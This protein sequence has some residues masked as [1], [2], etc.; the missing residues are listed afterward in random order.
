MARKNRLNH[1]KK[2]SNATT[3]LVMAISAPIKFLILG[4]LFSSVAEAQEQTGAQQ[5]TEVNSSSTVQTPEVSS[6]NP[7][8]LDSDQDLGVTTADGSA[9]TPD[10]LQRDRRFSFSEDELAESL[11]RYGPFSFHPGAGYSVSYNDNIFAGRSGTALNT[12]SK[13]D[14]L[15]RFILDFAGSFFT[16]DSSDVAIPLVNYSPEFMLY[17]KNSDRNAVNH[18]GSIRILKEFPKTSVS[19]QHQSTSRQDVFAETATNERQTSHNSSLLIHYVL[20]GKTTLESE[21]SQ[22]FQESSTYLQTREWRE[23]LWL[24]Y[25]FLPKVSA[26]IGTSGGYSTVTDG[27]SSWVHADQVRLNYNPTEK[28]GFSARGGYEWRFAA[29]DLTED[30]TG[31][32]AG[33]GAQYQ[34]AEATSLSFAA[35]RT[36]RPSIYIANE[37]GIYNTVS[38]GLRQTFLR[39]FFA[40][41]SG[42]YSVVEYDESSGMDSYD[43]YSSQFDVG[44]S[45]SKR[46]R[47]S[48]YYRRMGRSSGAGLGT[49]ASNEVGLNLNYHF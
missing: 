25:D 43:F 46:A 13:D 3:L 38:L 26:A 28:L 47:T 24:N 10:D 5:G 17:T 27:G 14:I 9:A 21:T 40:S 42:S 19:L 36:L 35:D 8:G 15:H 32:I 29:D 30:T 34:L 2:P 33:I 6:G 16:G 4:T 44:Y 1:R 31:F 11:F 48:V 37:T 49:F 22:R 12:R 18:S 20:G 23:D 41:L 7:T 39:R 45:I